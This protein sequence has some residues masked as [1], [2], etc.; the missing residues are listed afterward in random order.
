MAQRNGFPFGISLAAHRVLPAVGV[1]T[2]LP[3]IGGADPQTYQGYPGEMT[4]ER[5]AVCQP[6]CGYVVLT[7]SVPN[8]GTGPRQCTTP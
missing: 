7:P 3:R 1:I 2:A 4:V 6:E 5:G 8:L